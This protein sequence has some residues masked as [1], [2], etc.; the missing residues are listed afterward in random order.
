MFVW[1][2]VVGLLH[3]YLGLFGFFVFG[4]WSLEVFVCF[5]VGWGFA[6]EL[7]EISCLLFSC[8]CFVLCLPDS[9]FML[10]DVYLFGG[11]VGWVW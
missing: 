7:R 2:L 3:L 10:L 6:F 4:V 5:L 9:G 11:L 1:G 8:A